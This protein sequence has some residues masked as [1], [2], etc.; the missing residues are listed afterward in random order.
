MTHGWFV[1]LKRRG[2]YQRP[3]QIAF[4]ATVVAWCCG[5]GVL[6]GRIVGD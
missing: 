2:K 4:W 3:L 6:V 5:F 1:E